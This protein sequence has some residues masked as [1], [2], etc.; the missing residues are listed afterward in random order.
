LVIGFTERQ[1]YRVRAVKRL[2]RLNNPQLV[3]GF[4][5]VPKYSFSELN[6]LQSQILDEMT[7]NANG[8]LFVSVGVDVPDNQVE[9][10]SEHVRRARKL[11]E[12]L[13]GPEAPIRVSYEEPPAEV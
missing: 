2:P 5:Y 7:S 10:G 6:D 12:D 11:L 9:V 8:F 13:Y 3:S 1:T 4:P